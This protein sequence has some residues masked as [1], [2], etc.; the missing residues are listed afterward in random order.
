MVAINSLIILTF[1]IAFDVAMACNGYKARIVKA[2][3]CAGPDAIIMLDEAFAV[4]LNKKCEIVPTGCVT[5]KAFNT[6]VSK[7]KVQKDGVV[8]KE[9]KLDLCSA[10]EHV[11][12][13]AKDM[14]KLFGAPSSCPVPAEKICANDHRV[15]LSKYKAMLS[16]AK[17]NIIVDSDVTHD[18][19]KSCFH[20][21]LE[22]SKS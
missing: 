11:S 1:T 19:G 7:F 6:A 8:L 21:E 15:D 2:E 10:A 22:I 18:T 14:L 3:N 20:V 16:M 13:E 4:K 17:G 9:G 12:N 5:N